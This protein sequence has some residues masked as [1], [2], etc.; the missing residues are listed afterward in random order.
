MSVPILDRPEERPQFYGFLR[1]W[2]R[3]SSNPRSPRRA[4]A[5]P[6]ATV[7]G[8]GLEAFQ[9]S[10]APK[11][12]RNLRHRQRH[13]HVKFQSSIA[14]K[15]DRNLTKPKIPTS[16]ASSNPRSPR[17]ATAI[18]KSTI[19]ALPVLGSNPRSPRRATAIRPRILSIN[20]HEFQ[21]SI[22]PKSDRNWLG[23]IDTQQFVVP[24]LDRPEE[25]P[26]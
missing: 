25:R 1:R 23:E 24:I 17:R 3:V 4:T 6:V 13:K 16:H 19:G 9:S 22:A 5:M 18:V 2:A 26:Q 14:P 15:S 20:G 11:S 21:S 8:A 12:D 7:L 10:I